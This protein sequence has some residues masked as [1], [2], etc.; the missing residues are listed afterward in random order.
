VTTHD[1]DPSRT[2]VPLRFGGRERFAALR[3]LLLA[4][5]FT[6]S[7]VCART[8]ATSMYEFRTI[9]DGRQ[10]TDVAD[11]RDVLI[12]LFLDA[13]LVDGAVIARHLGGDGERLLDDLG[14]L[15][16]PADAPAA[17]CATVLLYPTEGLWLVSDLTATGA[18]S[19]GQLAPDVVYPAITDNTRDFVGA[20][21]TTPCTRCLEMCGGTGVAAL[22]AA[23]RA[24]TGHAWTADITERATRFAE[25]NA[26]LNDLRNVTAVQGDLYEPVRGLTFDRIVAHP[27]YVPATERTMIYRD[28][29]PDGEQ[30]T[31]AILAG[32]PEFLEPGGRFYLTCIATDRADAPLEQRIREMIGPTHAEYDVVVGVRLEITPGD[33]YASLVRAGKATHAEAA[34]RARE[35]EAMGVV[36]MVYHSAVVERHAAPRAPFTARRAVGARRV[37][38]A[39]DWQLAWERLRA[40]PGFDD[41]LLGSRVRCSDGLRVSTEQALGSGGWCVSR[42]ELIAEG[43]FPTRV[44][45]P[46]GTAAILMRCDGTTTVRDLAR[47]LVDEG[48]LAADG[49]EAA[50][51]SF[52]SFFIGAGCLESD[53]V[54]TVA[55]GS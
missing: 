35:C 2:G 19:A 12:R 51:V 40:S 15:R 52:A 50:T 23:R 47:A 3:A 37:G 39:L 10:H 26:L 34:Q 13:E 14:L 53:A 5:E 49:A 24:P 42:C 6:E 8:G 9:H 31:R 55:R 41:R 22:L 43:P 27:P 21:P 46:A 1:V 17:R 45:C 4:A 32:V 18:G 25:F 30:V 33:H 7:G 36:K 38:E 29:G 54:P 11:A 48:L 16:P 28:G 20:I 44:E